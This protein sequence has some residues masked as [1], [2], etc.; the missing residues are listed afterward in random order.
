[1]TQTTEDDLEDLFEAEDAHIAAGKPVKNAGELLPIHTLEASVPRQTIRK[2]AS[3][4]T[5]CVVFHAPSDDW[6]RPLLGATKEFGRWDLRHHKE[7]PERSKI[8]NHD[9][10]T[11]DQVVAL[12][13]RGC[14]IVGVSQNPDS[15]LP[16]AMLSAADMVLKIAKPTNAVVASVIKAITGR[17]PKGLPDQVGEKLS[18]DELAA[19]IRTG[20]SARDCVDRLKRAVA[21]K[22]PAMISS[23]DVPYVADL[24]GY[25][26]AGE[27]A[28]NL[29]TDVAAWREGRVSFSDI[30]RQVVL[31]SEPG[32]GKSTLLRSLTKSTGLPLV[33]SSVAEWFSSSNGYLDGV[34]KQINEL[35]ERA[36]HLAPAIVF[37]DEIDAVPN[38]A[39]MDK[40]GADFWTPVVTHLLTVL[41]S[42]V[43]DANSNLV[44]VAATN[45]PEKIDSALVRPG[46]LSRLIRIDR[47][48]E[49]A[50][51]GILRQHLGQDLPD[52]DLENAAQLGLGGTGADAMS[53]VKSARRA[54][55]QQGRDIAYDD[56]LDA[57]APR[58]DRPAGLLRQI[59]VHEAGHAVIGHV[60]NIGDVKRISL[61]Q[62][63]DM[64]GSTLLMP[65]DHVPSRVYLENSVLYALGGR[66]AEEVMIGVIASGAGG[67]AV[68]DL[69]LAT[70]TIGSIHLN[71]GLGDSLI[72]RA[73]TEDIPRTLSFDPT[74]SKKVEADLNRLYA[75]AIAIIRDKK[76]LVEAIATELIDRRNISSV[77][78]LEIV[79]AVDQQRVSTSRGSKQNG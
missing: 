56:L 12:L 26:A 30:E 48:D 58:E 73:N 24:H 31:Y 37:L 60:L 10:T 4:P 53:W 19:A 50:L 22:V 25:G 34:I 7:A 47:P 65:H 29:V 20:S 72:Y 74:L 6:A 49:Q 42:A 1:M 71:L 43:S 63:G 15:L 46:R 61:I 36:R 78:F 32:L 11:N 21:A 39:T 35:F 76:D 13:A 40:R 41:D 2:L 28:S 16:P 14:R 75:T 69:A 9:K 77:R 64:G 33:P 45:H 70:V 27:W 8:F 67:A 44:I 5:I 52:I 3:A 38:R 66:A 17:T 62:K 23:D 57:I 55:R 18:F 59:A 54:A 79:E 51:K 68:S